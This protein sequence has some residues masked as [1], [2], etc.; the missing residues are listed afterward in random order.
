MH[1]TNRSGS[2]VGF[3]GKGYIDFV[4]IEKGLELQAV[5]RKA[6]SVPKSDA[7]GGGH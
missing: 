6:I 4:R 7:Y 3:R 1:I 5:G 2:E